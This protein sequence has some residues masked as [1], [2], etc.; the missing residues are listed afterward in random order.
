MCLACIESCG[1]GCGV[2]N[3]P[4]GGV[5]EGA[6]MDLEVHMLSLDFFCVLFAAKSCMQ[7]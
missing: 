5:F 6:S 2:V 1:L 3:I 4:V 7:I